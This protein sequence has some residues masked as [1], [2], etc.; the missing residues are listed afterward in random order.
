[1]MK[2]VAE[3]ESFLGTVGHVTKEEMKSCILASSSADLTTRPV[4]FLQLLTQVPCAPVPDT[5][6]IQR[7][8][9]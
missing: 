8:H 9:R 7:Q 2:S 4:L 1:M 6:T 3:F 5:Y